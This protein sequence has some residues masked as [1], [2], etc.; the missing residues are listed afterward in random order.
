[1]VNDRFKNIANSTGLW[2]EYVVETPGNLLKITSAHV[3]VTGLEHS[4]YVCMYT[5]SHL[6]L[7]RC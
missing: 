6:Y 1:M 5:V 7:V 4:N 3:L 2:L